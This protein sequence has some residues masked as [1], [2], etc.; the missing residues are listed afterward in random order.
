MQSLGQVEKELEASKERL[1][2]MKDFNLF[3]AFGLLDK[4]QKG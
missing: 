2:L 4:Q 3:D 1:A